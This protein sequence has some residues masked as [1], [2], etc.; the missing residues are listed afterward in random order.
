[1]CF[2]LPNKHKIP[3]LVAIFHKIGVKEENITAEKHDL[4]WQNMV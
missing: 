1:M 2:K 4:K 3:D